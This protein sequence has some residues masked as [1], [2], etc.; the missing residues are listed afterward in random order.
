MKLS[1][2]F[3]ACPPRAPC[4]TRALAP[5][6]PPPTH[7]EQTMKK[8]DPERAARHRIV[9]SRFERAGRGRRGRQDVLQQM[10]GLPLDRRRRQEQG[11]PGVE[12]ARWPQVRHGRRLQ[13][14]GRQQELRHHL[15]RGPVQGIY[16]G[17]EGESSGNQDGLRRQSRT[18]TRSTISGRS[19]RNSTRTARSRASSAISAMPRSSFRHATRASFGIIDVDAEGIM[20]RRRHF[21][22]LLRPFAGNPPPAG[23]PIARMGNRYP[24]TI[25]RPQNQRAPFSVHDVEHVVVVPR[26]HLRQTAMHWSIALGLKALYRSAAHLLWIDPVT[27]FS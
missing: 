14:F 4:A 15:E 6:P 12:R 17:S 1:G 2:G 25:A 19:S 8:I 5:L 24:R 11:R 21:I 10:H 26:S 7:E 22:A 3:T 23:S 27:S 18:K 13:L 20:R 9:R 16:Q